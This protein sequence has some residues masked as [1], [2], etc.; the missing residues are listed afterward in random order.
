MSNRLKKRDPVGETDA[1]IARGKEL[2]GETMRLVE[3]LRVNMLEMRVLEIQRQL[4]MGRLRRR[5]D[6]SLD[7]TPARPMAPRSSASKPRRV[8]IVEQKPRGNERPTIH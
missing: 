6:T 5:C 4:V 7:T 1:L 2:L 3:R 8:A